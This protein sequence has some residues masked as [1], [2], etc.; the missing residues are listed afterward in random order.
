MGVLFIGIALM[1]R[2]IRSDRLP[3]IREFGLDIVR[4]LLAYITG[5]VGDK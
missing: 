3:R 5:L 1:Y 4:R 2:A